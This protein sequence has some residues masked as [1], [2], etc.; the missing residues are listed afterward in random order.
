[1]HEVSV[2][3]NIVSA[4][5]NELE[6]YD[7]VGVEEVVL[8][9]G[10]MT[11]LGT[12]QMRFAY[13]VVTRGTILENAELIIEREAVEVRCAECGYEGP[14]EEI[15]SDFSEHTIPI[16]S[17]PDCRGRVKVIKGQSCGVK[18]LKI[19]EAEDV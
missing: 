19:L 4:I 8:I 5:Q 6:K 16:L 10:D 1:M 9:I 11:S 17:C 14:V 12:D 13:E 2:I 15:R 7:A 3:S 18:N